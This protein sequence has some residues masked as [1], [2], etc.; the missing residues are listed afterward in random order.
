MP[1]TDVQIR[2]AKP[3]AKPYKLSDGGWLYLLVEPSGSKL[4]RM[5]Y[6]F[7]GKE[8]TLALGAYPQLALRDARNKR[9]EAKALAASGVDPGE[10]RKTEKAREA[11]ERVNTFD[12][13]ADE[14]LDK[15]RREGKTEKTLAKNEWALSFVRPRIGARPIHE[16]TAPEILACLRAVEERG[17]YET[18]VRLRA[19]VGQVFRYAIA[20]ARCSNDPTFAL[21][22]ALTTPVVKH[23][24]AI[25]EPVPFGGLL[26]A[27]DGY[28]GD[29]TTRLALQLLSLTFVRPGEMRMAEW[30]EV[31]INS[32]VWSIPA[33]RMKMRDPHRVPL[34]PQAVALLEELHAAT[35][36]CRLLFPGLRSI[37]RPM[38]ENTLNGAL[39]RLG[40]AQ[41]EM[42][43]HG[44]RA[45]ASSMLNESRKWSSDAIERQLAHAEPNEVRRAYARADFWPERVEMMK[46]WASYLDRLRA[47]GEVVALHPSSGHR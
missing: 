19:L 42:T 29:L 40:Y 32:A 21:R 20:T 36:R 25:V 6:R 5:G 17:R 39:R 10:R 14:M 7:A 15:K 44:F 31:D 46:W 26:R 3:R 13:I 28:A 2:N 43:A 8:K 12:T 38:S 33:R 16:I 30:S 18:A 1:L 37:E 24:P 45:A 23:R 27:I 9:D 47:G 35:G 4:W 11:L 41:D 34:A 22:G